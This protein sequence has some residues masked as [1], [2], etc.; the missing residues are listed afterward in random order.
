MQYIILKL[1]KSSIFATTLVHSSEMLHKGIVLTKHVI[2]KRRHA[3]SKKSLGF[4]SH[5]Q[6][7]R[8]MTL[9]SL[10]TRNR[11]DVVV[12]TI[13]RVLKTNLTTKNVSKQYV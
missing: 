2:L 12:R 10:T 6:N 1:Y 3:S 8:L 7:S 11:N 4:F 13:S 9:Q 5:G